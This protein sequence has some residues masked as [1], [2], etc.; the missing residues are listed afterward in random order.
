MSHKLVSGHGQS[1]EQSCQPMVCS[2]WRNLQGC[3]SLSQWEGG[4]GERELRQHK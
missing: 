3:C 1:Q 4:S 2:L